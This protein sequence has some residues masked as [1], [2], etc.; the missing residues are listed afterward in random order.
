MC[1]L[2]LW[3]CS[4]GS[5]KISEVWRVKV[6]VKLNRHTPLPLLSLKIKT[7]KGVEKTWRQFSYKSTQKSISESTFVLLLLTVFY[8]F[9]GWGEAETEHNSMPFKLLWTNI[10]NPIYMEKFIRFSLLFRKYTQLWDPSVILRL[11]NFFQTFHTYVTRFPR[12]LPVYNSA[13]LW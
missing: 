9:Y 2:L 6:D 4:Q 12:G 11:F 7:G 5:S 10:I 1:I 13:D 3:H 8:L